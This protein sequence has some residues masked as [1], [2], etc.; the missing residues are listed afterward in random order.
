MITA[1][2]IEAY[3][4]SHLSISPRFFDVYPSLI[5]PEQEYSLTSARAYES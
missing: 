1:P 3:L 2:Q 5:M 4:R